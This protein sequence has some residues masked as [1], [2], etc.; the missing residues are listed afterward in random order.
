MAMN[1]LSLALWARSHILL[2]ISLESFPIEV[3]LKELLRARNS[4][5]PSSWA[6][7]EQSEQLLP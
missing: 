2:D 4:P 3:P 1:R 7:V 5:V 6:V